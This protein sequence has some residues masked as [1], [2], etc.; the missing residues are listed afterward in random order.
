MSDAAVAKVIA[1][2]FSIA[3]ITWGAVSWANDWTLFLPFAAAMILTGIVF[4]MLAWS[5]RQQR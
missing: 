3:G 1:A 5:A 2:L 4:Q